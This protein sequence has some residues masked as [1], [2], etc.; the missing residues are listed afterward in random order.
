MSADLSNEQ[1]TTLAAWVAEGLPLAQI[2]KRVNSEFGLQITYMELRFLIDDLNLAL[3]DKPEPPPQKPLSNA[4]A[5]TPSVADFTGDTPDY[6]GVSA[7][8]PA[9]ADAGGVGAAVDDGT[10]DDVG[11]NAGS[12][13]LGDGLATG[14]V[15]VTV[16]PVQQPG[17][18][19][20]GTV[21][22]SDGQSGKWFLDGYGRLGF[23]PP[24]EGYH[25]SPADVQRFQNALRRELSAQGF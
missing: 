1:K 8:V 14:G 19:A 23:E 11:A 17:L 16:D 12:A 10:G 3:Q 4:P 7:K 24:S 25:P 15:S 21:T 13:D 6:S 5:H 18:A 20:S 9:G 2:Q 22:F